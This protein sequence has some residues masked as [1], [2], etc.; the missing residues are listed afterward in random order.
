[1]ENRRVRVDDKQSGRGRAPP[2]PPPPALLPFRRSVLR[3]L[4]LRGAV[5]QGGPL[6]FI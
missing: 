1:M 6:L 2:P 4:F 5:L 3:L